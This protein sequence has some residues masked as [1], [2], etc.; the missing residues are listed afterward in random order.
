MRIIFMGTP[1][2]AVPTLELL[3]K[4]HEIIAVITAPDKIGG[5]GH[6]LLQS[7]VKKWAH[8]HQLK[9]LQPKNLKSKTFLQELKLLN[10]DLQIVVAFRMLP[11]EVWSS[12]KYGTYNL[13][14]SLLPKYRGAAPIQRA[15][16]AGENSTGVTVFKLKHDIDT[17]DILIQEKIPIHPD[18]NCGELYDRMKIV[19]AKLVLE[20]VSLI[21][22][23]QVHFTKQIDELACPA[24]K[25]LAQDL[26]I[27]W[28]QPSKKIHNQIRA[29]SPYPGAVTHYLGKSYKIFKSNIS[30]ERSSNL[31]GQWIINKHS[32]T[33]GTLD[34][35][36]DI[37]EI[38]MEGKRRMNIQ[39][40]LN[41]WKS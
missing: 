24:P 32:L 39:E 34:F 26:E 33:I 14:G 23:N 25:I 35:M 31:S 4:H 40:F 5:R 1:E 10:A 38:Q 16:M 6:Q 15:I 3:H 12:P 37:L 27:N 9:I 28:L 11:E 36:L 8:N 21:E 2:F 22:Q 41:G 20:A 19:G 7:D 29:L 30:S 18:E 13:H 17:G